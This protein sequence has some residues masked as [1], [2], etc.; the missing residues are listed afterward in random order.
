MHILLTDRLTC[1]RCGPE[2][3]L[4]LLADEVADR[5]VRAGRLGCANCRDSYFIRDGIA[6]LR[7]GADADGGSEAAERTA[8]PEAAVRVGALLG[9]ASGPGPFLLIGAGADF[10][11]AVAALAPEVRFV[12]ARAELPV[13]IAGMGAADAVDQ[14]RVGARL[15]FRSASF[16]GAA[17]L[18]G[19][20]AVP[21]SWLEEAVR[22]VR[23]GARVL[24]D[25]AAAEDAAR[26][27]RAGARVLLEQNG[28]ALAERPR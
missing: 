21:E 14:V 19:G 7:T 9:V 8:D 23:P 27:A 18:R 1:P 17:L 22:V 10:A 20:V 2:F 5:D 15:P 11:P 16:G 24:V 25:P 26:L 3:G 4:I 13:E 12:A 28:L 6:D